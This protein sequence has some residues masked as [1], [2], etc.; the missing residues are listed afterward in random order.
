M[1]PGDPIPTVDVQTASE[2]LASA[3]PPLLLD[4]R[5][6]NEYAGV[7]APGAVLM[8]TSTFLLKAGELPRDRPILV[9]C[10]VGGRSA[11]VTAYLLCNGWPD[12]V[13]VAGGIVAWERAGLP[14]KR[15]A[16]APGEG[17]L[18]R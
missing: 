15:G 5:E 7:R 2:R 1:R 3:D 9:M 14:V 13:N 18:P 17:D 11:N 10:A 16:P 6:P 12:V 8:P 4:V